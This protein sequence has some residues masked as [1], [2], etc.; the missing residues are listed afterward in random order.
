MA[1][2]LPS[3]TPVGN[4]S[5]KRNTVLYRGSDRANMPWL[6][7]DTA[8]L[9]P[10]VPPKSFKRVTSKNL[11]LRVIPYTTSEWKKLLVDIKREYIAKH[12]R[13]CSTRCIEI[14][15]N[16]KNTVSHGEREHK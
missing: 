9:V 7:Q 15:D 12:Y 3:S 4:A 1:T 16:I 14:L 2:A 6:D 11:S 5:S 13:A 8:Q 10:P